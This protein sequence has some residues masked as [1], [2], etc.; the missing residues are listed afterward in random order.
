VQSHYFGCR[1]NPPNP[2]VWTRLE[3]ANP[4]ANGTGGEGG[5][6][7]L[8]NSGAPERV[9]KIYNQASK[10]LLNPEALKALAYLTSMYSQFS[11]PNSMPFVAW[12]LE[13]LFVNEKP[14]PGTHLSAL[15]GITMRRITGHATLEKLTSNGSGRVG[16]GNETAVRLATTLAGH[17][18]R[19]HR[20][21]VIFCDFNPRNVLVSHDKKSLVFVDAD[22]FQHKCGTVFTK[23][24][25]S[26]GYASPDQL[27]LKP[28][29]R[30]AADDNFVLAI[31]IFQLLTD[32]G[33]PFTT[34]PKYEPPGA[35]MF[36]SVTEDDNIKARRW[37]YSDV[38]KYH[39][40]GETPQLYARLH[41]DL[42]AMFVRAFQNFAPPT[43][44]EWENLLPRFAANVEDPALPRQTP[45]NGP[46]PGSGGTTV[47][48]PQFTQRPR[49]LLT[50]AY[51]TTVFMLGVI[52]W[53]ARASMRGIRFVPAIARATNAVFGY[54]GRGLKDVGNSLLELFGAALRAGAAVGAMALAFA[55]IAKLAGTADPT[56]PIQPTLA[57]TTPAAVPQPEILPW[58]AA[59]TRVD[60]EPAGEVL[61]WK[62]PKKSAA[63][64][65]A[66]DT[67]AT[68]LNAEQIRER[69]LQLERERK[70]SQRAKPLPSGSTAGWTQNGSR[71][72]FRLREGGTPV[73]SIT[74]TSGQR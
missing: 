30:C 2:D 57:S 73:F 28:G 70:A 71:R 32:G 31:H 34:G 41:P 49:S 12:P 63:A 44:E 15:A 39:P 40:P 13:V 53:L 17:L 24:H 43:A 59:P 6:F 19:M 33:H 62:K 66:Q 25:F 26:P 54:I 45:R 18:K 3:I 64:S 46:H 1:I 10:G 35:P 61:P 56:P 14:L 48:V 42:K 58:K 7:T 72:E 36:G 23:P 50:K 52:A 60:N 51:F 68:A 65:P 20:N 55:I 8:K 27:A 9:A 47:V 67:P 4:L 5:I 38:R 21:E 16:L 74:D 69:A 11:A 22:A 37:P 29:P